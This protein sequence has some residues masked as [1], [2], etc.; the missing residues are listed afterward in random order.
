M[1][2]TLIRRDLPVL[3]LVVVGMIYVLQWFIPSTDFANF[4]ATL[5]IMVS[6]IGWVAVGVGTFYGVTSEYYQVRRNPNWRQ[7]VSSGGMFVTMIIMG[8]I[9]I[10]RFPASYLSDEWKWWMYNVYTNQSQAQYAIMWLFQTG[11]VY[12]VLRV[13][14]ID[15]TVFMIAGLS[16]ILKSVPLFLLIPGI[17][18]FGSWVQYAPT[19]AGTR[20]ATL[21]GSLGALVIGLR[22]LIGREQTTIAIR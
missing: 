21:T 4:K 7:Y 19:L 18:E 15:A 13:R 9:W 3:C 5:G 12:R 14:S 8:I 10:W 2:S 6:V 22:A 16:F 20:A 1:S 17:A 11:A